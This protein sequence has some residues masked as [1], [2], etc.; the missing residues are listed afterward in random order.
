[1]LKFRIAPR[2]SS[3]GKTHREEQREARRFNREETTI[4]EEGVRKCAIAS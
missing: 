1:M 2:R 3:S 4:M